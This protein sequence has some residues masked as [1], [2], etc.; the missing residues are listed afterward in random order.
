MLDV[1]IAILLSVTSI[2]MAYLGVHLTMH[3]AESQRARTTYKVSFVVCGLIAVSLIGIQTYRNN[4]TWASVR[5]QMGRIETGV[6][7]TEKPKPGFL[8]L[9]WR[10]PMKDGHQIAVGK[11]LGINFYFINSSPQPVKNIRTFG[12]LAVDTPKAFEAARNAFHERLNQALSVGGSAS[13]MNPGES[14]KFNT[15][16]LPPLDKEQVKGLRNGSLVLFMNYYIDWVDVNG[17]PGKIDRC[18][19]VLLS[20]NTVELIGSGFVFQECPRTK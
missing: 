3:P 10:W 6:Q 14:P 7:Q 11:P 15:A 18:D 16:R 5:S 4:G 20:P 9:F 13:S 19:S 2:A 12:L 1:A 8:S 17:V